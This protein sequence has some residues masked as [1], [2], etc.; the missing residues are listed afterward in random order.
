MVTAVIKTLG[1][2]DLYLQRGAVDVIVQLIQYD[3]ARSKYVTQEMVTAVIKK[4]GKRDSGVRERAVDVI[5]KQM[6]PVRNMSPRRQSLPSL[7]SWV[8]G[9]R[10]CEME[11]SK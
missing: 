7:T 9:I 8:T 4:L 1:D 3:D 5:G 6:I 11:Q 10:K 2:R